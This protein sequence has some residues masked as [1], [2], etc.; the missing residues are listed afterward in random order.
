MNEETDGRV[1]IHRVDASGKILSVNDEWVE[2]ALE[3]G[4]PE[5]ARKAVAGRVIWDFMDGK[6]TRHLSRLLLEKVRTS[7]KAITLPYRCDSPALKRYM[8]M[9]IVQVGGGGIEFRIR[10]IRIETREPVALIDIDAA[11]SADFLTICSWCT[12]ARTQR[13]WVE[14][15]EAVRE[16]GL[17]SMDALPQI[18]HGM[19]ADCAKLII[20]KVKGSGGFG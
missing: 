8:E 14:L 4:A 2:F 20:S 7:G 16:L 5:L 11:R 6:E 10:A 15:D 1:F 12:R 19:C 9:E 13:G 18:T 3:N 17:F